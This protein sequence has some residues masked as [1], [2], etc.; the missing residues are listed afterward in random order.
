[1][2]KKKKKKK[3]RKKQVFRSRDPDTLQKT[4][5][6]PRR[7]SYPASPLSDQARCDDDEEEQ[8][9]Q[10]VQGGLCRPE[11]SHGVNRCAKIP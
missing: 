10:N 1:M 3:E 8:D 6:F 4:V 9:E 7:A 2:K 5:V 11:R